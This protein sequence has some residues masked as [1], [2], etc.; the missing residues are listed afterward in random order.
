MWQLKQPHCILARYEIAFR[1]WQPLPEA[2]AY[3][4]V[5]ATEFFLFICTQKLSATMKAVEFVLIF[6][7]VIW[8]ISI[9]PGIATFITAE[10]FL[11]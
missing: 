5:A 7:S 10:Q 2:T 8:A 11:F 3:I 1:S 4:T 9:P 6:I